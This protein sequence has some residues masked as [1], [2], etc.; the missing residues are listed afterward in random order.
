M[1]LALALVEEDHGS[2]LLCRFAV[3][4]ALFGGGLAANRSSVPRYLC[5]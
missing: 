4:F 1:D 5:N 2:R 3:I